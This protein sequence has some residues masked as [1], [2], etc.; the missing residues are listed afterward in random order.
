M[1]ME[2]IEILRKLRFGER[3]AEEETRELSH[4]FVE[5]DQWNQTFNGNVDIIYGNK[6]SGKSAIYTLLSDKRTELFDRNILLITAENPRGATVFR[7]LTIDPPVSENEFIGLWKLYFITLIA[8]AFSDYGIQN[9]NTN[10]LKSLLESEG[11][12]KGDKTLSSLLNA[13]INYVKRL[14]R[15][16][17]LENS[18]TIDPSGSY[19]YTNRIIF[20]EPSSKDEVGGAVS[21]D[22]LFNLANTALKMSNYNVWIALDRL[23][24]AFAENSELEKN[25]LRALFKVYSDLKSFENIKLKIFLRID[26][27]QK[28][29][30]S[31]F[32]EASHIT[33]QLTLTWNKT[34]VLNLIMRRLLQNEEFLDYYSI[35]K[36]QILSSSERQE[37]LFYDVFPNQ[38]DIG[39]R[40]PKTLD[41]MLSRTSD[42]TRNYSPRE[43]IHLLNSLLRS[44]IQRIELGSLNKN[45][46]EL[47]SSVTFK[48]A[49]IEVSKVRLEQTLYAEFPDTKTF[50]SKLK[51][52][53]ASQSYDSLSQIWEIEKEETVKV[54]K[55]LIEIGFFEQRGD[56]KDP[57][58]WTPFLYRDAL[59]LI[60][61]SADN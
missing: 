40:K 16:S 45:G 22:N 54:V 58:L 44:E 2:K 61:G 27:W 6:G 39:S 26:I 53:K 46:K 20:D 33:K 59:E 3:V 4:Y 15:P 14:F 35:D 21:V 25:A 36:D 52:Q 37:F 51:G 13:V 10:S 19:Q 60:Q 11:L 55:K 41:W 24:V 1:K 49:L 47:F 8:D 23:D 5:T 32:R 30:D 38:V 18:V 17:S 48:T 34:A 29:V 31:G 50:I 9:A 43:M 56:Q 42:G 57:E 12:I 7:N 28:I